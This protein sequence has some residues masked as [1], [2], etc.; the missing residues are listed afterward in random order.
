MEV[1]FECFSGLRMRWLVRNIRILLVPVYR[2]KKLGM[3]LVT[4]I[5]ILRMCHGPNLQYRYTL[6]IRRKG[7]LP[8]DAVVS[9]Y[10]ILTNQGRVFPL[11]LDIK[12]ESLKNFSPSTGNWWR[13][14]N[15]SLC[16]FII[17]STLSPYVPWAFVVLWTPSLSIH[18]TLS[19]YPEHSCTLSPYLEHS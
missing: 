5:C 9:P 2:M 10:C 14:R 13:W 4:Y 1:F 3:T 19:P 11:T 18:S 16:T 6:R 7:T 12:L 8:L 17:H 15:W